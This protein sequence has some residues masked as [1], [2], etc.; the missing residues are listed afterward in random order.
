[1]HRKATVSPQERHRSPYLSCETV[2]LSTTPLSS[3][4]F[5]L[6]FSG[7]LCIYGSSKSVAM[8]RDEVVYK[9]VFSQWFGTHRSCK[10]IFRRIRRKRKYVRH[11]L[12]ETAGFLK[13]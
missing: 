12:V 7:G 8:T 4:Q 6:L 1:M 9:K 11:F 13:P 10:G 2:D 5:T 3:F